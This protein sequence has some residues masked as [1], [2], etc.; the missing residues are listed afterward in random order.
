[1][2]LYV[3]CVVNP[4]ASPP[5]KPLRGLGD[6]EVRSIRSGKL[7]VLVSAFVGD[8]V[9]ITE[10]NVV[11]H[12]RVIRSVLEF[13]TPLPFRFGTLVTESQLS[14]YLE[15]RQVALLEKLDAL[16]GCVEMSVK[17]IWPTPEITAVN[18]DDQS[19]RSGTAFLAAKKE[20]ILGDATLSQRAG[21][22]SL[23][24][25]GHLGGLVRE[26]Q[27]NLRP[28][29]RLVLAASHLVE[30]EQLSAYKLG[31]GAARAERPE[32]HFLVSGPWPPYSF[33]NIDLEFK[34]QFG[35]S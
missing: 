4:I 25:S 20:E 33:A 12:Q 31:L 2:R 26:E 14:S 34:S 23:W 15:S 10:E 22:L 19:Q 30:R 18:S 9:A 24:L 16:Q 29:D 11:T 35:V 27:V 7:E 13:T 21:D 17:V 5:D 28:R 1:M 32:L 6:K 8:N 3:Y